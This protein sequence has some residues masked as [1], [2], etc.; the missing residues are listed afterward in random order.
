MINK[1]IKKAI[2]LAAGR[3]TRF[4]PATKVIPKELI[5]IGNYP[6][7]HY[8]LSEFKQSGIEEVCIIVREWGSITEQYFEQDLELENYLS[9][10]GKDD[11]LEKVKKTDLGLKLTFI[12][13]DPNLPLGHGSALLSAKSFIDNDDFIF[14]FCDDL[15]HSQIPGTQQLIDYRNDH[16]ELDHVILSSA[17]KPDEIHKFSSIKL[18]NIGSKDNTSPRLLADYF[19]KPQKTSEI[20]EYECFIGRALYK[21]S[22]IPALEEEL[23]ANHWQQKNSEFPAWDGMMHLINQK[24]EKVGVKLIDGD[25]LTTGTPEEMEKTQA[26]ILGF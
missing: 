10:K 9:E 24:N 3:G 13:Q 19:E 4:L 11:L 26:K 7:I 8:L 17:V 1:Q 20:F 21:S 5:P 6:T 18:K 16:P 12:K 14:A 23:A 15:V 2:L 22:I 25:W